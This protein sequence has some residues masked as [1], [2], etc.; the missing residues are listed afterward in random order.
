MSL[1]HRLTSY[2]P[3]PPQK[4]LILLL[5]GTALFEGIRAGAGTFRVLLDLP[6]RHALGPVAF[7][8]FSRATDLSPTGVAFYAIYGFGG[9]VVTAA[10]YY[11][12]LRT[13]AP[14]SVRRF[15]GSACAASVAILIL[16][17]RA[18]P[19][20]WQVGSVRNEPALLASL[21]DRFAW[22]TALRVACADLSFLCVIGAMTTL[23]LIANMVPA[24][25]RPAS[26]N[27]GGDG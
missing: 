14:R 12:A 22:W 13:R 11:A 17:T 16:T 24:P 26:A 7:A 25:A 20:V 15:L 1:V 5:A 23:L 2:K 27:Q 8:E 21:L 6:A 4:P 9:A 3:T 19:L 18:A 10:A